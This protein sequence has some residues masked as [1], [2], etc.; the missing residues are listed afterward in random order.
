MDGEV[1]WRM[2][3]RIGSLVNMIT[4]RKGLYECFPQK[5]YWSGCRI[6]PN[7][8]VTY[9][10]TNSCRETIRLHLTVKSDSR[11][12]LVVTLSLKIVM[13]VTKRKD[14]TINHREGIDFKNSAKFGSSSHSQYKNWFQTWWSH[15]S[16]ICYRKTHVLKCENPCVF[17]LLLSL[18][19]YHPLTPCSPHPISRF[20]R[21]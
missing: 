15:N 4:K 21:D 17:P 7:V 3:S 11:R 19:W 1:K 8:T 13:T 9:S 14:V 20:P 10:Y 6:K 12:F 5:W 2:H 16:D 18:R